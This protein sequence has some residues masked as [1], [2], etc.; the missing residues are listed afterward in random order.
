MY[1]ETGFDP[2][3]YIFYAIKIL[4][5]DKS[6]T[7]KP[8]DPSDKDFW[9]HRFVFDFP[10][11]QVDVY[12]HDNKL[13][14]K[15]ITDSLIKVLFENT[16]D[17]SPQARNTFLEIVDATLGF[18]LKE[19]GLK[20]LVND[21]NAMAKINALKDNAKFT[22]WIAPKYDIK[23]NFGVVGKGLEHRLAILLKP[24]MLEIRMQILLNLLTY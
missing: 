6:F 23:I 13:G 16:V 22:K 7:D 12:E 15:K 20:S 14:V 9:K 2:N 17:V 18:Y 4:S 19:L 5:P 24:L 11:K 3:E 21:P 1:Q 8:E 10:N